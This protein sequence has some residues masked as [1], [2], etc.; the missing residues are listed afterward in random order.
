MKSEQKRLLSLK[1]LEAQ[2]LVEGREWTRQRLEQRLQEQAKAAG[3]L[4]P[5]APAAGSPADPPHRGRTRQRRR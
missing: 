3:A 5:P 1:E 4:S 2:V